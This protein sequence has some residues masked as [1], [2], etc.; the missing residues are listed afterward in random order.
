MAVCG[1]DQSTLRLE[2]C[3]LFY[4]ILWYCTV[5]RSILF[6]LTI[7]QCDDITPWIEHYTLQKIA[8]SRTNSTLKARSMAKTSYS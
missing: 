1:V 5:L 4:K 2:L 6:S 8:E 7:G 3:M